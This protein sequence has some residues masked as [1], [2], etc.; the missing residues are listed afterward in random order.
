[1]NILPIMGR[2]W[3]Y[4]RTRRG[5]PGPSAEAKVRRLAYNIGGVRERPEVDEADWKEY[6]NISKAAK[7]RK[8]EKY[9]SERLCYSIGEAEG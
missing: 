1:M 5:Q 3:R 7:G 8:M 9:E 6:A 4:N 2:I